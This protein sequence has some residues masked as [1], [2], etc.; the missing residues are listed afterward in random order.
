MTMPGVVNS[1]YTLVRTETE[2]EAYILK[3]KEWSQED[4]WQKKVCMNNGE[5]LSKLEITDNYE[6]QKDR[7]KANEFPDE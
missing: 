1:D 5:T 2:K 6:T 7:R 4:I 3:L